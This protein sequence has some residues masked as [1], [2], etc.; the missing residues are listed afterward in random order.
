MNREKIQE[1]NLPNQKLLL[2][3]MVEILDEKSRVYLLDTMKNKWWNL[4]KS[5]KEAQAYQEFMHFDSELKKFFSD[6]K[7]KNPD[8]LYADLIKEWLNSYIKQVNIFDLEEINK[9]KKANWLN[10][11]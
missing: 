4:R 6:F 7:E 8:M 5:L 10:K 3:E 9:I 2:Y 1:E 11:D